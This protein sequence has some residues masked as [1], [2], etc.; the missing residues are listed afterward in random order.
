MVHDAREGFLAHVAAANVLMAVDARGERRFGI[1]AV[2]DADV[3]EADGHF[4]FVESAVETF[5]RVDFE[6]GGEEMGGVETDAGCR[7]DGAGTAGVEDFAEMGECGTEASS[8]PCGVFDED[9]EGRFRRVDTWLRPCG[10]GGAGDG[11]G[12]VF[13]AASD[14]GVAGRAGMDDEVVGAELAG[15][16]DFVAEGG[17]SALPA[18]R[19][20]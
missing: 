20:G 9:A 13:D 2:N 16:N 18:D 5:G 3:F 6:A 1:V 10:G 14:A 11:F 7:R 17:D 4:D 8:L 15:T 19:V 12:D